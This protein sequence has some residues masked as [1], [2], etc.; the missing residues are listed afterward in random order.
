LQNNRAAV[1]LLLIGE[2]HGTAEAPALVAELAQQLTAQGPLQVGLEIYAQEQQRLDAYLTSTG[3]PDDRAAL[4]AGAFWQVLAERSD[5]RRSA[6][7]LA[8]IEQLRSLRARNPA[9]T[10]V[11]FDDRDFYDP[12]EDRD[13]L[14]AGA[15]RLAHAQK[16]EVRWLI[17]TGNYHA[18]LS[19][20]KGAMADGVA[21]DPP[22]PMAHHLQDLG[23]LAVDLRARSGSFWAC[24]NRICGEQRV[25]TKAEPSEG[26][27]LTALPPG[28]RYHLSVELPRYTLSPPVIVQS[29]G[30]P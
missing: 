8:L 5:G 30:T 11:A 26:V 7:T 28:S 4:L 16:P 20:P 24:M 9:L 6:A 1:P 3:K 17:L 21:I 12:D 14:M 13:A 2:M 10:V 27:I 22:M 23:V 15:I 18:A 29:R 19:P 25:T